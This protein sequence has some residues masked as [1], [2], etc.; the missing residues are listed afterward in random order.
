MLL[1]VEGRTRCAGAV[2]AFELQ[3]GRR[4]AAL[5]LGGARFDE[6]TAQPWAIQH[7][8]GTCDDPAGRH[9]NLMT[10]FEATTGRAW[11]IGTL[12]LRAGPSPSR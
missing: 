9:R 6:D 3:P 4:P 1:I 2:L 5:T 10:W 12:E 8:D 11:S 7:E